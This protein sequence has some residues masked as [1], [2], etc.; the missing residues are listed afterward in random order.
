MNQTAE[1]RVHAWIADALGTGARNCAGVCEDS[2]IVSSRRC[3]WAGARLRA[4]AIALVPLVFCG[5]SSTWAQTPSNN[6]AAPQP[7]SSIPRAQRPLSVADQLDR[8]TSQLHLTEDQQARAKIILD[9]RQAEIEQ[10]RKTQPLTA[11]DRFMKL[12]AVKRDA[13]EKINDLLTD[14]QRKIFQQSRQPGEAAPATARA[15]GSRPTP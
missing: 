6:P 10:I 1:P 13:L 8:L 11:M 7:R 3:F 9:R 4:L 12:D 5:S 15:A 2:M 14:E